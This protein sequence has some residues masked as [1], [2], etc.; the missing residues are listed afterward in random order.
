VRLDQDRILT[1]H[2]GSLPRPPELLEQLWVEHDGEEVDLARLRRSI[3][4]AV[5]S[6]VA[7]QRAVG[8]DVVSDGEMS[9]VA[10]STYV[11]RRFSG[12]GG[13]AKMSVGD[14]AEVPELIE[15]ILDPS[16]AAHVLLPACEGP[17]AAGDL[18]AVGRDIDNLKAALGAAGGGEAFIPAITPGHLTFS[19]PNRHYPSHDAYLEAAGVAL[20]DEYRAIVDAGIDLQLDS[21][22][23]AMAGH[24]AVEGGDM[25]PLEQHIPRAFEVLNE[26]TAELPPERMRLHV[27]WGSYVGPHHRDVELRRIVAEILKTRAGFL[28]IE[29]ANP[30]HEHEW[31]VWEEVALPDDKCLI[32]GVVDPHTNHV[33]HPR[34]VAQR[35]ERFAN[36]VGKERVVAATD[37]GF[38]TVAGSSPCVPAIAWMKLE[39]LVQG[40]QL[41]SSRLW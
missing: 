12:F 39:A 15:R 10:F 31:E 17:I 1:T 13:Q 37:C 26:A 22:D 7:R 28:Y 35:I 4:E 27:C 41:A 30:R 40:A 25:P 11:T 8:I 23:L 5:A 32:V 6:V 19:F 34:L 29:A 9:K 14:L 36:L 20:R 21:P 33:E 24:C 2:G 38:A 18:D 3:S 16:A